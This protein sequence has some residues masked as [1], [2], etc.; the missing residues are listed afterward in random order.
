MMRDSCRLRRP[1]VTIGISLWGIVAMAAPLAA[2]EGGRALS[3]GWDKEMLT[4]R[5]KHLPGG[6]LEVWYIEA[7]CRPGSTHRDWKQTVIPHKTE[8]IA[9]DADGRRI[10]LRSRLDDGVVVDHEIRAGRDEV[11]FRVVATNPTAVESRAQ[12][13]QP[14]IRV[15]RYA[16]TRAER[17][18]SLSA[19]VF[20]LRQR[21][22]NPDAHDALGPLRALH[23]GPGLVSR[24]SQP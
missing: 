2:R 22:A 12:W 6:A 24:R 19:P 1:V 13:A 20:P 4:I 16:G 9:A 23:A 11:D 18:R 8:R 15:D 17:V 21:Q 10:A 7:Y 3:L 14:C 5:G